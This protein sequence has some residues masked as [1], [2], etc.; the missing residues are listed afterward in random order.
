ML[1]SILSLLR[2]LLYLHF[3]L[4]SNE[5]AFIHQANII[6]IVFDD[7]FSDL[8]FLI[9]SVYI[10]H[11]KQVYNMVILSLWYFTNLNDLTCFVPLFDF[12][13]LRQDVTA[14]SISAPFF[15]RVFLLWIL[16]KKTFAYGKMVIFQ[17]FC[18]QKTNFI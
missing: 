2:S 11:L 12:T 15:G 13:R 7:F 10:L 14:S 6:S 17:Q 16:S 18:G 3:S 8:N 1:A 5:L 4:I 9:K